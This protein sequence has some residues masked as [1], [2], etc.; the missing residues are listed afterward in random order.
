MV[1]I[2]DL[3]HTLLDTTKLMRAY[4]RDVLR[5]L[6]VTWPVF[7]EALMRDHD[8]R[9]LRKPTTPRSIF[10]ALSELT[11][12][13]HAPQVE[14]KFL[15]YVRGN[16]HTFFYPD[17]FHVLPALEGKKILL[18]KGSRAIQQAKV[19][20]KSVKSLFN[21]VYVTPH[22]KAGMLKKI[23]ARAR[24][25]KLIFVDDWHK[26][27]RAALQVIPGLVS[28]HIVRKGSEREPFAHPR[29]FVV[30]NLQQLK[31]ITPLLIVSRHAKRKH[32]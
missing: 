16:A 12:K 3:D 1:F 19:E 4:V 22:L 8:R 21:H 7:H 28:V 5:P 30:Q 29:C 31:R 6:G 11:G 32:R 25:E 9:T 15:Q 23:A 17:V 2:F 14:E 20:H 10:R 18:T 24:D 13:T 27:H 26:E